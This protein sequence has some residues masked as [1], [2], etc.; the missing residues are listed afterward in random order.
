[1]LSQSLEIR[2][3][4]LG[5]LVQYGFFSS[6]E[7]V[8][9][10]VQRSTSQIGFSLIQSS[11]A[12]L[13][14]SKHLETFVSLPLVPFDCAQT[15]FFKMLRR[16]EMVR[17][18]D[19]Q[20]I[21]TNIRESV[22]S[23]HEL[24]GLLRWLCVDSGA[25]KSYVK[26]VLSEIYYRETDPYSIIQLEKIEFYSTRNIA[27]LPL[28]SNVLPG[29]V[30]NHLSREDLHQYL[31]LTS[32]TMKS[33]IEFY[34]ASKQ[35]HLFEKEST[36]KILFSLIG[37]HWNQFH[38]DESKKIRDIVGKLKCIPTTH[39]M[40]LPS[41]SYIR[42][43]DLSSDLPI[44]SLYVPEISEHGCESTSDY[45]VTVEFLKAIGCRTIHVPSVGYS[46]VSQSA[47]SVDQNE[48]LKSFIQ[49]LMKRRKTMSD[50]DMDALKNIPCLAG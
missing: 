13:S 1:M 32:I 44:V 45:P 9:V 18:L 38:H 17:E 2:R 48:E 8:L 12:Y 16:R 37:Q 19:Y 21:L 35:H 6:D 42:S 40:Q 25:D 36:S 7:E 23:V 22:L 4:F 3:C 28:P 11:R 14:T 47:E 27:T 39:G 41:E 5:R 26:Q 30:V 46:L 29:S 15:D 31:S 34:I 20:T 10:P 50:T 43:S 24:I 49:D 33:L